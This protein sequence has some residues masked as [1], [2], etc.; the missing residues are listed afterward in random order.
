VLAMAIVHQV[1][2]ELRGCSESGTVFDSL[3]IA[4]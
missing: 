4:R 3:P 2:S 1:R